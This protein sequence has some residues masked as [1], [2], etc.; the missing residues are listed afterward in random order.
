MGNLPLGLIRTW[1]G[2]SAIFFSIVLSL[3]EET[4]SVLE[5]LLRHMIGFEPLIYF[6]VP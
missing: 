5:T 2:F 6:L 1:S 3:E 4:Y